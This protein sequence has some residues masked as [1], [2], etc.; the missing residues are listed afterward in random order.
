[1]SIQSEPVIVQLGMGTDLHAFG[2][3]LSVMLRGGQTGNSISVMLE[4]TPPGGGPPLHVHSWEDEI[5][6]VLEGR[7]SYCVGGNWTEVGPG[8][9]VYLPR[10]AAHRYRNI[11]DIPS[12]HWIITLPSGFENFFAS[13]AREFARDGG[14]DE[15][16]IVEIH[17][18]YG[19]E[20][21]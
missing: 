11:G 8:G 4:T 9:V 17:Q 13:C 3:V 1:M 7:I 10:G 18:E 2:N 15:Q 14:P 19:I 16:R 21:L 5:F 6:L 12:W 20:L